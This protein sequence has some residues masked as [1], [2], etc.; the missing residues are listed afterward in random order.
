M[1]N[2]PHLEM[3]QK[4]VLPFG[5][6]NKETEIITLELK[7]QYPMLNR[8]IKSEAFPHSYFINTS[9]TEVI[10]NTVITLV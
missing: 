8:P 6:C 3:L 7:G 9:L 10:L 1:M 2:I 4:E 5:H